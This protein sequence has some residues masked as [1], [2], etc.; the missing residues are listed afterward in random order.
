[1]ESIV[2]MEKVQWLGL[3][4]E[5]VNNHSEHPALL[6]LCVGQCPWE[7]HCWVGSIPYCKAGDGTGLRMLARACGAEGCLSSSPSVSA[8]CSLPW[9]C[10]GLLP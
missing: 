7:R 3:L 6:P 1:M 4:R 2:R 10:F 9:K 8:S 5:W